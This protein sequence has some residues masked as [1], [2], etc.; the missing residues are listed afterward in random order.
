MFFYFD[1]GTVRIEMVLGDYLVG[2][3]L[4]TRKNLRPREAISLAQDH[5]A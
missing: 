1:S 5:T 3:I 4:F 2:A